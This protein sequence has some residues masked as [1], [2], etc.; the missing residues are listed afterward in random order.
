MPHLV[1]LGHKYV[2]MTELAQI[3]LMSQVPGVYEAWKKCKL[4]LMC[5]MFCH[6][7]IEQQF[8]III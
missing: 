7:K 3:G 2:S 6:G 8:F 5:K 4:H 1:V